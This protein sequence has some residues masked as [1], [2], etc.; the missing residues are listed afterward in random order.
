MVTRFPILH[1]YN[2][3]GL[4]MLKEISK[5]EVKVLHRFT[6]RETERGVCGSEDY[7][8]TTDPLECRIITRETNV[9]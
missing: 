3:T 1:L 8:N 2:P 9:M 7:E 5:R 4:K 6:I